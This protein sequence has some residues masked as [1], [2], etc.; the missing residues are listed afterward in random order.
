M[1]SEPATKEGTLRLAEKWRKHYKKLPEDSYDE[2]SCSS[3]EESSYYYENSSD[4]NII[5]S[6]TEC[7]DDIEARQLRKQEVPILV[8]PKIGVMADTAS[9]TEVTK[10]LSSSNNTV[11][12]SFQSDDNNVDAS[13]SSTLR[14]EVIFVLLILLNFQ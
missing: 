4:N 13:G 10:T 14:N 12:E 5:E 2:S 9:E 7:E 1:E 6:T 8:V 11:Y 3:N